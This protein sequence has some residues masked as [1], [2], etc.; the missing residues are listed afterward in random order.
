[1]HEKK[2]QNETTNAKITSGK[3]N[4]PQERDIKIK[5]HRII[6]IC[7]VADCFSE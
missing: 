7:F 4:N 3:T 2:R 1:M 6:V 5:N